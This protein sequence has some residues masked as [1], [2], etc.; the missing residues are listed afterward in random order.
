MNDKPGVNEGP[1]PSPRFI[2][3]TKLNA[4]SRTVCRK[5]DPLTNVPYKPQSFFELKGP[6]PLQLP[7][8]DTQ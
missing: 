2:K 3:C 4:V 5:T 6:E 1:K 8:S 7:E